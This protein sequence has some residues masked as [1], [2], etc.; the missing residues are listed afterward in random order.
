MAIREVRVNEIK[1][2]RRAWLAG[3]G[4]RMAAE[5][6]GVD[7]KTARRCVEAGEAAGLLRDNGGEGQLTDG[8]IGVVVLAVRPARATGHGPSWEE[9]VAWKT[10]ITTWVKADLQLTNIHGKLTRR[11]L[12]SCRIGRCTGSRPSSAGSGAN[13]P[14][15][16]SRTASRGLSARSTSAGSV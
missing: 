4:L 9:L 3:A 11:G 13:A 12:V 15:C 2:V 16:G 7:R 10:Q 6:A 8:M 14:R 5:R 1:E